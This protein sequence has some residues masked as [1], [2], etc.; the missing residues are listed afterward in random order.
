MPRVG[1][2][3]EPR[4]PALDVDV[5]V[6][7]AGLA[8]PRVE[9][10]PL[11]S[12]SGHA[13]DTVVLA[14]GALSAAFVSTRCAADAARPPAGWRVP[15]VLLQRTRGQTQTPPGWG[16]R[17]APDWRSRF[18]LQMRESSAPQTTPAGASTLS[19]FLYTTLAVTVTAYATA[20]MLSVSTP[21]MLPTGW[22]SS[23]V[24]NIPISF[25]RLK[26]PKM[27]QDSGCARRAPRAPRCARPSR[28]LCSAWLAVP[29]L[30]L[31]PWR[32][33]WEGRGRT[34]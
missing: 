17:F 32:P 19:N 8:E 7:A 13:S 12:S 14:A 34:G 26:P 28:F 31:R 15:P 24:A 25:T 27:P 11:S 29:L 16:G 9:V 18:L 2:A 23:S 10:V 22:S 6:R 3:D 33:G 1:E 20:K 5:T 30:C 21:A 4:V